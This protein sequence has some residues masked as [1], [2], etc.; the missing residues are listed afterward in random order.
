ML[1]EHYISCKLTR[2]AYV[3]IQN[4]SK[5]TCVAGSA[6]AMEPSVTYAELATLC[7]LS[8][9]DNISATS[10]SITTLSPVAAA[11]LFDDACC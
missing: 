2:S 7:W 8:A 10:S 6:A 9:D 11:E 3:N 1:H 5:H 4:N